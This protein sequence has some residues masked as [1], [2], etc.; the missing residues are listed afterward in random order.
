MKPTSFKSIESLDWRGL[1]RRRFLRR[2]SALGVAAAALGAGLPLG[3][4]SSRTGNQRLLVLSPTQVAALIA[5]TEAVM[6]GQT[7]F[8]SI[9]DTK[10]VE[11]LDEELWFADASIQDD[12]RAALSV[13]EWLPFAYGHFSRYSHLPLEVRRALL[14]QLMNSRI[15][16]VRAIATNLRLLTMFFYFGHAASWPAIGYDGPFQKL[17]PLVSEQRQRYA[18][19]VKGAPA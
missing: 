12:L 11:R 16:T 14:Q 15:E 1:G 9:A 2:I 8:P 6:P 19:A 13:F 5:V 3:G 7:G 10:V 4:C 18:D 17:P